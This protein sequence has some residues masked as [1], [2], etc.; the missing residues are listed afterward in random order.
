MTVREVYDFL[1][2]VAPY[3]T[4][5]EWD[6]SG[7]ITGSFDKEVDSVMLCLDCTNDVIEQAVANG[8][9]L[10]VAHHPLIFKPV[11]RVETDTP[12]YNAIKNGIAVLSCHTN[13]DMA[14]DGVN[15]ALC[16]VLDI[17][18]VQPIVAENAPLMR[19]G[20]TD[21]KSAQDFASF[22]RDK[23]NECVRL[24]ACNKNVKKVAVCGGA[25]GEYIPVAADAGCDT[26]VTGEAK[27]HEHLLA[28][29][30][31]IN[32]LVAGHFSTEKIVLESLCEKLLKAFPAHV[33]CV[34]S[35]KCPYETV[36]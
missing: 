15:D 13:L 9:K 20:E 31:G 36:V 24:T 12:L 23:L 30:Y 35:E 17:K 29:M 21:E 4:Q 34:A 1:N 16:K 18:D 25:G 14:I 10:I 2:S 7:F 27:H 6:N 22:V 3:N 33:I 19:M 28:Q 32:L 26:F 8:C 5:C 11:K